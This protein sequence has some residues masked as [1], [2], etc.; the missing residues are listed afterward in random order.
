MMARNPLI[1]LAA[2]S[3]VVERSVLSDLF[4]IIPDREKAKMR[5]MSIRRSLL[6][7]IYV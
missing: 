1:C 5:Y 2:M 3:T 4:L 6:I 7:N